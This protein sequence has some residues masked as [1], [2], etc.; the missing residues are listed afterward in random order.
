MAGGADNLIIS[1]LDTQEGRG[2]PS[3][4][5]PPMQATYNNAPLGAVL[6]LVGRKNMA[7]VHRDRSSLLLLQSP[8]LPDSYIQKNLKQSE[9][10]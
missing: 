5:S 9:K 3:S 8:K 1:Q 7:G 2:T 4:R 10:S 6:P